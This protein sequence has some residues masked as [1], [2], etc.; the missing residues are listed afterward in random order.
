V[1]NPGRGGARRH[2]TAFVLGV[3]VMS[4]ASAGFES[5]SGAAQWAAAADPVLLALGAAPDPLTGQL[6][7]PSEATIRRVLESYRERYR[8]VAVAAGLA[9][10]LDAAGP[11]DV[12]EDRVGTRSTDFCGISFSLSGV[13]LESTSDSGLD[14]G[15]GLLRACWGS[16]TRWRRGCRLRCDKGAWEMEDEDLTT[17]R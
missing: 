9:G 6:R 12:V 10:E 7:A 11:F 14:R 17:P 3:L 5:F 8:P 2:P 4:F 1:P 13:E 16:S 15:I